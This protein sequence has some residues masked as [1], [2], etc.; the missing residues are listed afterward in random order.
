M[1]LDMYLTKQIYVGANYA[2][3]EVKGEINLTKHGEKIDIDL[4]K[5]TYITEEVAYW[6]KANQIHNWF[7]EHVQNGNDDC[8]T[9]YVSIEQ[10]QELVK[11]C[12]LILENRDTELARELLPT[13]SGFFFGNTDYDDDYFEDL[14]NTVDQ[15]DGLEEADYEYH[16]SW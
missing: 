7:V 12:K 2:F 5:V 6:R 10:I 14:E 1:G 8:G 3:N 4:S 16:S 11:T 9:Y 13:C 15:L